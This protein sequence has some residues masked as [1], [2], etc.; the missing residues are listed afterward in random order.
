MIL[1]SAIV[2]VLASLACFYRVIAGPTVPDRMAAV[3]VTGLLISMVM[4]LLAS[5]YGFTIFFDI[6]LV[7]AALLFVD[8]MI[9]AKYLE[10]RELYK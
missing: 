1:F 7:Y 5:Y 4:V 3:D 2:L 6:V 9:M 8:V 10:Y